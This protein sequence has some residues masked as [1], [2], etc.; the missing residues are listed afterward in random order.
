M[1]ATVRT[2]SERYLPGYDPPPLP[3]ISP[4]AE[5]AIFVRVLARHGYDDLR[6]GHITVGQGDGTILINPR[7]LCWP[8][9]RASD[10]VTIDADGRKL[11]GRYNPTLAA[12][13]H[14]ELRRRRPDVGVIVHNHPHWA[15]VW[16]DCLRIP[17]IYDQTSASVPHELVLVDE[18]G[19]NFTGDGSAAAA[20][21]A[22]G[23]AEWG[24]LANHG[25]LVTG[26]TIAQTFIRAYTLEWRS[27]RA[28]EVAALGGGRELPE[29]VALAYGRHFEPMASGWWESA[30]RMEIARDPSVLD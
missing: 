18:Y 4:Q 27:Q 21:A 23:E 17:P 29:D 16:G 12:G 7:E 6:A 24:L 22:F 25:V 2:G 28:W 10:I 15:V 9:V 1:E 13:I 19:G 30:E 26:R 5:L 11:H 3:A 20:A 8:E 14:I